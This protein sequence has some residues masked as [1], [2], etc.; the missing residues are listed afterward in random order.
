[1][2]AKELERLIAERG[3]NASALDVVT[4][5]L[6]EAG[7]LPVGGR[8]VN[9]AAL[10]PVDA[11]S[12]LIAYAGSEVAAKAD[13]TLRYYAH[14]AR[15]NWVEIGAPRRRGSHFGGPVLSENF[16][17]M[18]QSLLVHDEILIEVQAISFARNFPIT[19]V[20][21]NDGK[22][23]SYC[24]PARDLKEVEA[25]AN[26]SFRSEGVLTHNL[27]KRIA[28]DLRG[29]AIEGLPGNA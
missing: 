18:L 7:F 22:Q 5:R 20:L 27:L 11:A 14:F 4:R 26:W 8:G 28:I 23:I 15:P 6:R 16:A 10:R 12:I 9:A 21:L 29:E 17:E 24:A 1:M 19:R 2:T 25:E 13:E 3:G